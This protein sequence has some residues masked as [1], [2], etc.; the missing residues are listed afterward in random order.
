MA[1]RPPG[2]STPAIPRQD[3]AVGGVVKY[4]NAV[5]QLT[6]RSKRP[7]QGS[8]RMSPATYS[9]LSPAAAASAR[10]QEGGRRAKASDPTAPG[11]Q[12][13]GELPRARKLDPAHSCLAATPATARPAP[14]QPPP[15]RQRQGRQAHVPQTRYCHQ[16]RQRSTDNPRRTSLRHRTG[17]PCQRTIEMIISGSNGITSQDTNPCT[18][19]GPFAAPGEPVA[20]RGSLSGLPTVASLRFAP[21]TSAHGTG[22]P[23]AHQRTERPKSVRFPVCVKRS[24][25]RP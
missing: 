9:T 2:R 6:T 17:H 5:D 14:R 4:P 12:E 23:P 19:A 3:R 18:A 11:S 20:C 13:I 7:V 16:A 25:S 10:I 8:C 22:K 21:R 24:H 1:S 15:A